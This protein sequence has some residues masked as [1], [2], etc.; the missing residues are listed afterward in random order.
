MTRE[1]E[2]GYSITTPII[3]VSVTAGALILTGA[4]LPLIWYSYMP[5]CITCMGMTMMQDRGIMDKG[6]G[7]YGWW[8][9]LGMPLTTIVGLVSGSLVILGSI[10]LGN[11]PQEV[12]I[13]GTLILVSSIISL[14]GMGGFIIGPILGIISGVL[15]LSRPK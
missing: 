10:M 13:W 12:R 5:S 15:A 3:V 6:I 11:K 1:D 4:L 2:V 8:Q 9:W 14:L 7:M